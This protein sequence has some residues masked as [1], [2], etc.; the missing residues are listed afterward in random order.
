MG[1]KNTKYEKDKINIKK[2]VI[3]KIKF[4]PEI[5]INIDHAKRINS[6]WPISGCKIRK[7]TTP[8]VAKKESK[9]FR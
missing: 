5:K 1:T 6:V 9:Y 8:K 2:R 7:N 4:I 3:K